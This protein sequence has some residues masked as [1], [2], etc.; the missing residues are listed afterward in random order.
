MI[1]AGRLAPGRRLAAAGLLAAALSG[2][3]ALRSYRTEMNDTLA[4]AAGGD[5]TAAVKRVERSG[6]LTGTDLLAQLELGELRRLAGDYPGSFVALSRAD[7]SLAADEQAS[8]TNPSRWAGDLA[9][10]VVND[11]TRRYEAQD[12]EKV[13]VTTRMAMDHL[14]RGDWD[15]A[16][17]EIKR[18]HE[19][20]ALVAQRRA[21]EF[22]ALEEAARE[23]GL[24][25]QGRELGGY[26]V[27]V[28]STPEALI[29]RNG[30][31]N[32]LSHY[33]AGFVYEALGEP[34]LAAPGYRKAIE[35]RPAEPLLDEA[36]AGLDERHARADDGSCDLLL[37]VETGTIPG[38]LSLNVDLP[39]PLLAYG[40]FLPLTI[41][42]PVLPPRE[43]R[44]RP[45]VR[46][47]G[48]PALPAATV[49]D[50]DAMARR[51][52]LDDL[53]GIRLR[54]VIRATSR[55]LAQY[56]MHREIRRRSRKGEDTL[57]AALALFAMQVG[58]LVLEQADE[59]SWRSLPAAV[60]LT[61]VRLPRGA[62]RLTLAAGGERAEVEVQLEGR[63]ALATVRLLGALRVAS[64]ATSPEVAAPTP[65]SLAAPA[66]SPSAV[67]PAHQ[68]DPAPTRDEVSAPASADP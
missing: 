46:V 60:H 27:Q 20:E 4:L 25:M 24:T 44:P 13:M 61:R 33:L 2:C 19:R 5:A 47:D 41:A 39:V 53:P 22:A 48:G 51:A 7:A 38:R 12:Y 52:L 62:H 43:P 36:L 15:S 8:R 10:L 58:G 49:L 50:L 63:H 59:R 37:L 68:P 3:G 35:L 21:R 55:A 57:G 6:G 45:E 26:P 64:R 18:T 29:L 28:L 32:A 40:T 9:S 16:R 66:D 54:A 30:Y 67:P 65:A 14:A 56:E 31:Q 17:V 1:A 34:G 11:R 23:R 42:F